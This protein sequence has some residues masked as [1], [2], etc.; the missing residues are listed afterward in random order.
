MIYVF[1]YDNLWKL[2]K[3]NM[4]QYNCF[5]IYFQINDVTGCTQDYR[6]LSI[7]RFPL[8]PWKSTISNLRYVI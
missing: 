5:F 2:E 1:N 6:I 4:V 7:F 3:N 8:W